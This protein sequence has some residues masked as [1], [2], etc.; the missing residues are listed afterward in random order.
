MAAAF[1]P[2]LDEPPRPGYGSLV[3]AGGELALAIELVYEGYLLH[4]RESRT[5]A[6]GPSPETLLLAGDYF[7]AHGLR[8]VA[9]C[10]DV[11]AVGLLTRLMAACSYLRVEAAAFSCDDGLWELTAGAVGDTDGPVRR[12]AAGVFEDVERLIAAGSGDVRRAI[13]SGLVAMRE[14]A[15]GESARP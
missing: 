1:G 13:D 7:Y 5:I 9:Q 10:G 12:L 11:E 4:Y 8:L 3:K 6:A 2:P 15:Q 14:I